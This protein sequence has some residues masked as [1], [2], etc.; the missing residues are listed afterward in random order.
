M[1]NDNHDSQGKF[2]SGSGGSAEKIGGGP[3]SKD[4]LVRDETGALV[5][6]E[7]LA[8][9]GKEAHAASI[10]AEKATMKA[11]PVQNRFNKREPNLK[12]MESAEL[13]SHRSA[14]GASSSATSEQ[15]LKTA[16]LHREAAGKADSTESK[17]LHEAAAAAHEKAAKMHG[18]GDARYG[19]EVIAKGKDLGK[20]QMQLTNYGSQLRS[21]R[22]SR[23]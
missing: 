12:V 14:W 8:P 23:P 16:A 3:K 1:P 22:S 4:K 17:D 20:R 10:L 19:S 7:P 5:P 18:K 9:A 15:H 6:S 11:A 13:A 21:S 2:S